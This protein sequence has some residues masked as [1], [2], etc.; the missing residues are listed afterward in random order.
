MSKIIEATQMLVNEVAD[1]SRKPPPA[2]DPL[3]ELLP[4]RMHDLQQ[5]ISSQFKSISE[6][7][8]LDVA[9]LRSAID[10]D[11]Q[12]SISSQL[13]SISDRHESDV[14]QLRSA[15]DTRPAPPTAPA[16]SKQPMQL[17]VVRIAGQGIIQRVVTSTGLVFTFNR[18][19]SGLVDTIDMAYHAAGDGK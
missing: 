3:L 16:K 11:L 14:A 17:K 9:R 19:S 15:I 13:R 2:R 5:S 1:Q 18:T 4:R 8:E 7:H 6:R 12:Q 10:N